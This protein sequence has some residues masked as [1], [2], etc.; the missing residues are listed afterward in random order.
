[1]LLDQPDALA[2]RLKGEGREEDGEAHEDD[3]GDKHLI[4]KRQPMS[5]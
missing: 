4:S 3:G 5:V 2:D 1:M